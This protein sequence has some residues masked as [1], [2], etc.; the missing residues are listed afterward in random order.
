MGIDMLDADL[1][2]LDNDDI[3]LTLSRPKVTDIIE[4]DES[5]RKRQRETAP[6]KTQSTQTAAAAA[7]AAADTETATTDTATAA[8]TDTAT[9]TATPTHTAKSATPA[10]V[11]ARVAE[12]TVSVLFACLFCVSTFLSPQGRASHMLHTHK[13]QYVQLKE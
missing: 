1:S 4:V 2:R 10:S 11:T 9:T 8:L 12:I 5:P 6:E 13:S 7:A 3:D